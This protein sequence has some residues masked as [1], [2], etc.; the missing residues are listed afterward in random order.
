MPISQFSLWEEHKRIIVEKAT[1]VN[2][3]EANTESENSQAEMIHYLKQPPEQL[4]CN[5]I[6]W[7]QRN[8]IKYP[9]LAPKALKLL[10]VLGTSVPS[11][12][13]FSKAGETMIS[14]RN[15]LQGKRL[16]KLL[17]LQSIHKKFWDLN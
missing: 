15:S 2:A 8:Y 16:S 3:V 10:S 4:E 13:L 1:N 17:F 6:V 5:P 9:N 11:E 14:K 7:W 12:R